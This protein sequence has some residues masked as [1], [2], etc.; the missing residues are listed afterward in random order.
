MI[1]PNEFR[2]LLCVS[3]Y[4]EDMIHLIVLFISIGYM[5]VQQRDRIALELLF[6][7]LFSLSF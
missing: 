6:L 2:H 1:P 4:M 3:L 7:F 5:Q